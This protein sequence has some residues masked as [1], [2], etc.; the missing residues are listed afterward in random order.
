MF[1]AYYSAMGHLGGV[2]FFCPGK[3][4]NSQTYQYF[5]FTTLTTQP[6]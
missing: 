1:A 6:E 5:S 2:P 3:A 4:A